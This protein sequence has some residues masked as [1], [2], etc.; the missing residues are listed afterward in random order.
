M[1]TLEHAADSAADRPQEV[2]AVLFGQYSVGVICSSAVLLLLA[3]ATIDRLTGAAL[4]VHMLYII[5][6]GIITWAAGR[7]WGLV[8]SV[9]AMSISVTTFFS[10]RLYS[11]DYLY[12]WEAAISLATLAVVAVVLHRLREALAAA[13]SLRPGRGSL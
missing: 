6:V 13:Q 11:E 4:H 1:G 5:P 2:G 3:I 12:Y 8:A 10:Q 9:A 7:T